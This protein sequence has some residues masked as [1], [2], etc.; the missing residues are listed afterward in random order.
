MK[1]VLVILCTLMTFAYANDRLT[2]TA[3][4]GQPGGGGFD[5]DLQYN[6]CGTWDYANAR[7]IQ[8]SGYGTYAIAIVELPDTYP[9]SIVLQTIEFCIAG[10]NQLN[11]VIWTGLTAI[12]PPDAPGTED[13]N[14]PYT[15]AVATGGTGMSDVDYTVV[16]VSG[17]N[18]V[19]APGDIIA[20]GTTMDAPSFVGVVDIVF[21]SAATYAF[22]DGAWDGDASWGWTAC[23]Q[24]SGIDASA[25]ERSTWGDI[26]AAF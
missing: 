17:E 9:N 3:G 2:G 22:W 5:D 25:L 14:I 21:P 19:M 15:P 6:T 13:Y 8:E 1:L 18:I 7:M 26:K 16:D 23:H 12:G 4:T 11:A 20:F 24:L 10:P